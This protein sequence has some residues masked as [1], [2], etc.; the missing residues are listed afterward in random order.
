MHGLEGKGQAGGGEQHV[1]LQF[2]FAKHP[3][4]A[5]AHIGC[6]NEQLERTPHL[7]ALEVDAGVEQAAQRVVIERIQLVGREHARDQ[8]RPEKDRVVDET[9]CHAD[10]GAVEREHAGLA[11]N[12]FPEPA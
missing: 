10:P 11:A 8:V 7:Q 6:A 4:P 9:R 3:R 5:G 12:G 2:A 1:E